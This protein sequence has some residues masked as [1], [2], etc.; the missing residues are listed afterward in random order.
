[1]DP[2]TLGTIRVEVQRFTSTWEEPGP[3]AVLMSERRDS[4]VGRKLSSQETGQFPHDGQS[5]PKIDEKLAKPDNGG[6][7]HSTKYVGL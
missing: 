5:A 1:M 4:H 2:T 3:M 6:I 7:T